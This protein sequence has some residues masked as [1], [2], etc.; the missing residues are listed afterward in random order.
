ML[1]TSTGIPEAINAFFQA[2]GKEGT[3][4]LGTVTG[5]GITYFAHKMASRDNV[6]RMTIDLEREK[7]LF[8]QLKAKD[9]RINTLHGKIGE[10]TARL[11]RP[12][13]V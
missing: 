4:A 10:L 13:G 6:A 12:G 7:E 3:F 11:G 1:M 2:I 8:R 9:E 5:C